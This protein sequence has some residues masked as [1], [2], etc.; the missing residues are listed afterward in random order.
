MHSDGSSREAYGDSITSRTN[1]DDP[2]LGAPVERVNPLGHEV[3]LLSCTMLN[4]GEMLG[5]GIFSVPGVILNSVGSV[6]MFLL[7]WVLAP[8]FIF[9]GLSLFTELGSMFPNRSGAEVVY[10]E[11]AYPRPRSLVPVSF[12][13]TTVLLSFSATNAIVFAQYFMAF[14]EISPTPTKQTLLALAMVTFALSVP[15]V[16]TKWSL[17]VV[18]TITTV[19]VLSQLILIS[20]GIVVLAGLTKLK[21]PWSNFSDPWAGTTFNGNALA[22]AFVKT[23]YAFVG[24]NNAFNVLAEVKGQDPVQTVRNSGRIAL[25][26]VSLLFLLSNIAYIAAIPKEDIQRSGQLVGALFFQRVFGETW[27]AKML[28]FMVMFASVGN[29]IAVAIGK[30][31]IIREIA[32]QG[33]LPWP[34]FFASTKPF[35]TPLGPILMKYLLTVFVILIVPAADAF[36]F[37]LDLFSYPHLFFSAATAV[38]VWILRRRRTSI[39][40]KEIFAKYRASNTSI[41]LYLVSCVFLI[42]MPWIPPEKGHA[43]VSFWYATYCVVGILILLACGVYYYFWI[44]LLPR[45]GG[46]EVVEEVEE[47]EGGARLARLVRRYPV[48][49]KPPLSNQREESAVEGERSSIESGSVGG[50]GR[51]RQRSKGQVLDEREPLL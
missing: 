27:A 37:L 29:V 1:E 46:Y 36:S 6:G 42:V 43:D 11:Q 4:L 7:A 47:L 49:T 8:V 19:K 21:D 41:S 17:L 30:A 45:L 5:S 18:N 22:T 10:L 16:S 44:V 15:A 23:H 9:A 39:T 34:E 24:W 13:V 33:L 3:G 26:L 38:G 35:G 32:R 2:L 51:Q 48:A 20:A 28:P 12:A 50:G 25:G 14:F 40:S 31:R